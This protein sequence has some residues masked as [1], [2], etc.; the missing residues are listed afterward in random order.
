[1][2]QVVLYGIS[3]VNDQYRIM[4]YECIDAAFLSI[5]ELVSKANFMKVKY[6]S[7]KHVYAIDNSKELRRDYA[8]VIKHDSIESR[9]IFKDLMERTALKIF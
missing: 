3:G 9:F 5:V 6:P 2:N 7:I 8:E 1:M 4:R